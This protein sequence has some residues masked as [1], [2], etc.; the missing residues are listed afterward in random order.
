[1]PLTTKLNVFLLHYLA[2]NGSGSVIEPPQHLHSE[3]KEIKNHLFK[4]KCNNNND[5]FQSQVLVSP[6]S[7]QLFRITRMGYSSI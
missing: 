3:T 1:M 4:S 2:T 5:D 7:P 6:H